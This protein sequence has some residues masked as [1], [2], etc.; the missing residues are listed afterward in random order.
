MISACYQ[1]Q[2]I[3]SMVLLNHEYL[4][5]NG[6]SYN[7]PS[8]FWSKVDRNGPIPM[9]KPQLGQCWVWKASKQRHG[10]GQIGRCNGTGKYIISSRASWIL[11]IGSIPDGL[12][13]CHHC[14]NPSCVRPDHL[15]LG[16]VLDNARDRASKGRSGIVLRKLDSSTVLKIKSSSGTHESIAL[17]FGVPR[18]QVSKILNGEIYRN[19]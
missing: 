5:A 1:Q 3:T 16:T 6:L 7:F 19:V 10:Y 17:E 13:V 2:T 18:R 12:W 8:R 11:H 15:F 14:D 4:S 9:H